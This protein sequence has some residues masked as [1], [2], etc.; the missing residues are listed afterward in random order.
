MPTIPEKLAQIE[1]LTILLRAAGITLARNCP[2]Q[3]DMS[4]IF[5][6]IADG[7]DEYADEI[8][9]IYTRNENPISKEPQ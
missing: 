6:T 5:D 8:L 4:A 7:I 2:E 3:K 1:T 9:L